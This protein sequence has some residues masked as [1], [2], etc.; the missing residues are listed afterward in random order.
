M[1]KS[2][3]LFL[4]LFFLTAFCLT[5]PLPAKAAH[6]TIVVP[7][8]HSTIAAAIG[9]ALD[10]DTIF[11]KIGN[12]EGPKNQT[13]FINKT[14]SLIGE[15]PEGTTINLHPPLVPMNIFTYEY[16]GYL[17]AIKIDANWVKLSGFTI[18][19]DGGDLYATGNGTQIIGNVYEF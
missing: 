11:V 10:G 2:A 13:L 7:D 3:A 18:T 8:D 14:I 12:Y 9:T 1:G 5:T 19:S 16:M 6:R 4:V 15:D 17:D